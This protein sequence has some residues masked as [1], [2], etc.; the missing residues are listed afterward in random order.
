MFALHPPPSLE[1]RRGSVCTQLFA[2]SSLLR[3]L[4]MPLAL[5]LAPAICIAAL[6][7]IVAAPTTTVV[8]VSEVIRKVCMSAVVTR[9][10]GQAAGFSFGGANQ[11]LHLSHKHHK[12]VYGY[13]LMRPAREVLFTVVSR[14]EKYTA[15]LMID[16]VVQRAGDALA[17]GLFEVLGEFREDVA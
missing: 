11:S 7:A 15:K 17:A 14:Q 1:S 6:L 16:T 13:A 8:A 4:G 10:S 9:A 12:Q 3:Y 5:G 2:T